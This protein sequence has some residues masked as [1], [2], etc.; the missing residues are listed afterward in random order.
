[1]HYHYNYTTTTATPSPHY[2][3]EYRVELGE[4]L[5]MCAGRCPREAYVFAHAQVCQLLA[6]TSAALVVVAVPL[7]LS[8]LVL[9]SLF[10]CFC[11]RLFLVFSLVFSNIFFICCFL[12]FEL[13]NLHFVIAHSLQTRLPRRRLLFLFIYNFVLLVFDICYALFMQQKQQQRQQLEAP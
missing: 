10:S 13:M 6:L 11:C 1:M 9:L 2:A 12:F 7:L 3:T 8:L 5:R 4:V